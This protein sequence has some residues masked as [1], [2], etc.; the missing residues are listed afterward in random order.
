MGEPIDREVAPT[1]GCIR[2]ILGRAGVDGKIG[3]GAVAVGI[4]QEVGVEGEHHVARLGKPG[5]RHEDE[6]LQP[7]VEVDEPMDSAR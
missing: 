5:V 2:R 6:E 3:G 7:A 1:H 4:R